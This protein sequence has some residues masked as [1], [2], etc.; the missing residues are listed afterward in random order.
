MRTVKF[1][2]LSRKPMAWAILAAVPF[3]LAPNAN[4]V[5]Q[6]KDS[7][8]RDSSRPRSVTYEKKGHDQTTIVRIGLIVDVSSLVLS[9]ASR[10]SVRAPS[11]GDHGSS[12]NSYSSLRVQAVKV[13][14]QLALKPTYQEE[15]THFRA[16]VASVSDPRRARRIGEEI[17]KKFNQAI[18]TTFDEKESKHRIFVG[19]FSSRDDANQMVS[20]LRRAGFTEARLV[21]L[22]RVSYTTAQEPNKADIKKAAKSLAPRS[23]TIDDRSKPGTASRDARVAALFEEKLVASDNSVL[24]VAPLVHDAKVA[25]LDSKG[26]LPPSVPTIRVGNSEYRGEIHLMLNSRG[27]LNVINV[28][29]MEEYLRGVVPLELPP[30]SYPELEALKAQAIAARSYALATRGR[31]GKEGF[32]LYDDPRSQIYGGYKVEHPLANRAVEETRG[33]VAVYPNNDGGVTP[34]EALYSADCGGHTE[35]NESVFMTKPVPYLRA[36]DCSPDGRSA[37]R[38]LTGAPAPRYAAGSDGRSMARDLALLESVGVRLPNPVTTQWLTNRAEEGE[39]GVWSAALARALGRN[40]SR[41]G[42]EEATR[43][44]GFARLIAGSIYGE[45]NARMLIASSDVDYIMTGTGGRELSDLTRAEL[46]LLIRDDILRLPVTNGRINLQAQLTR[47]WTLETLSRAFQVKALGLGSISSSSDSKTR[48]RSA[49]LYQAV[50]LPTENNK[51]RVQ[52]AGSVAKIDT[53]YKV[54]PA[55]ASDRKETRTATQVPFRSF[56]LDQDVRLFRRIGAESYGVD[57]VAVIGGEQVTYHLNAKGKV[58]FLEVEQPEPASYQWR[59]RLTSQQV[60]KRLGKVAAKIGEIQDLVPEGIGDSSRV[61]ELNVIGAQDST[62]IRGFQIR[63]RLGLK[64][65]MFLIDRER[66]D[67]GRVVAFVF[68]GRGWGHGVGLC[69]VGSYRLAKAGFSY[70][71]ILQKY[72]TG[73]K[74]QRLY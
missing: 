61:T 72:Y 36:V 73:V 39:V 23:N 55:V 5:A 19:H 41:V 28:L 57:R 38:Q 68:N 56:E 6:D 66:D 40:S 47:E 17:K 37:N 64:D 13:S 1:V 65:N 59:E 49:T 62:K 42:S 53:R 69:Q 60:S 74:V 16:E 24:I 9:S 3:T 44:T 33:L 31:L 43:L 46:A 30:A 2:R 67:D 25:S 15:R 21:Q 29:P 18:E 50:A 52:P 32:D 51:L 48:G 45:G 63:S 26:H 20:K 70:M 58:D 7:H 35:N 27:R 22:K 71:R 14:D 54:S 10:L 11:S 12:K 4:V 8:S 34:I